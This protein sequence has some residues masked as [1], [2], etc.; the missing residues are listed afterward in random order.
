MTIKGWRIVNK[1]LFIG[2]LNDTAKQLDDALSR[3]YRVQLCVDDADL[4]GE[5]LKLLAPQLVLVSLIG[6]R[7]AHPEIFSLLSREAAGTPV[8]AVG[9]KA[10]EEEL[11]GRGLL[12]GVSFLRHPVRTAEIVR[13]AE[14][15]LGTSE[16]LRVVLLVDDDPKMLR[17]IQSMLA[18]KFQVTF[19]TS[20]SKAIAAI[21]KRR[22][23][24]ILLD[25]DMP[26]AD[27]KVVFEMLRAEEETRDIP[28]VFLT[29]L[30]DEA[31]VQ[32]VLALRPAGYMLK[33]PTREKLVGKIEQVLA[34]RR[35]TGRAF[36]D[37]SHR[38]PR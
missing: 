36:L 12:S 26:V 6:A 19:A 2:K 24:L 35:E 23:D 21:L 14:K 8:L 33:P 30:S 9:S 38:T 34:S 5:M 7:T 10:F 31:H 18:D 32:R 1:V 27:G 28:I 4:T 3:S 16:A 25:Y 29:G 20:G 22:P 17:I 13:R 37:E 11:E 15:L